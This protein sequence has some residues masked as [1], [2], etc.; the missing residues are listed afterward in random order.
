MSNFSNFQSNLS[1]FITGQILTDL[2]LQTFVSKK[3]VRIE[4][5][6]ESLS[7]FEGPEFDQ[8]SPLYIES[9]SVHLF[10]AYGTEAR[11]IVKRFRK[12]DSIQVTGAPRVTKR[13]DGIATW[14]FVDRIDPLPKVP[15]GIFMGAIQRIHGTVTLGSYPIIEDSGDSQILSVNCLSSRFTQV[16]DKSPTVE[17]ELRKPELSLKWTLQSDGF[18]FRAAG[19]I[20]PCIQ[21]DFSKGDCV[22]VEGQL[23]QD[24]VEK[25]GSAVIS[26]WVFLTSIAPISLPIKK[27][28]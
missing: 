3:Q 2:K 21:R 4:F 1:V 11:K 25:D 7:Y 9:R 8:D 17:S 27:N 16:V 15:E 23:Q 12:G 20:I 18:M 24:T 28:S 10:R 14:Y 6:V 22:Y 13:K 19:E 5:L 26:N